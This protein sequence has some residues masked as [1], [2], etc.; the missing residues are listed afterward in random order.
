MTSLVP[1]GE[2]QTPED[3]FSLVRYRDRD[4]VSLNDHC[5]NTGTRLSTSIEPLYVNGRP[6]GFC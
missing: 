3:D 4:K 6:I 2:Y 5:P 1:L